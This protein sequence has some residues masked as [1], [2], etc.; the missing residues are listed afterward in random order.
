MKTGSIFP[1]FVLVYAIFLLSSCSAYQLAQWSNGSSAKFPENNQQDY[2][3]SHHSNYSNYMDRKPSNNLF[4]MGQGHPI[5]C[6]KCGKYGWV[7]N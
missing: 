2:Y 5:Y 3:C 6:P 1:Y 7:R 4:P